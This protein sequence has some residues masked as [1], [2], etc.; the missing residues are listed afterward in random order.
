MSHLLLVTA[1]QHT[2]SVLA[3]TDRSRYTLKATQSCRY[4]LLQLKVK[5]KVWVRT[6]KSLD[7]ESEATLVW[8]HALITATLFMWC[9][10]RQSPTGCKWVMNA[11]ARVV[12][13]T[14]EYD[15]TLKTK[16]TRRAP[17]AESS[18]HDWIQ[19]WCDGV[20]VSA[21]CMTGRLDTSL[22]TLSQPLMLLLAVFV[23]MG[24]TDGR[25]EEPMDSFNAASQGG[26]HGAQHYTVSS[27]HHRGWAIT[28]EIVR[29]RLGAV[30]TCLDLRVHTDPSLY[31]RHS[32]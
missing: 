20:P 11:A 9:H 31:G 26:P 23:G 12:S 13:Y 7:N 10:R 19:A 28:S 14:G 17:L 15:C 5:V 2:I 3:P 21:V 25:M 32:E 16:I 1:Q 30:A 6:R 4:T 18:R 29:W 22:I 8:R 27:V 24:Q